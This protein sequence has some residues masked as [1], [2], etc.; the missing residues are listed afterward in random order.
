[1]G[2]IKVNEIEK[3][4]ASEITIN[5]TVKVDT[6]AEKTSGSGVTV[7]G[8]TIK[9]T[10]F[11]EPVKIKGYTTTQMNALSGMGAGDM[12]YNSTV[13]T[14]YV[15]NGVTW[16]AMS[17]NTYTV[18]VDYLIIAGG[19]AG[20]GSGTGGNGGG[21]GAGGYLN[22]YGSD[23]SG[24]GGSN[25][26]SQSLNVD[27]NYTVTIGAGGVGAA[28]NGAGTNGSNSIF[29]TATATGGGR[30]GDYNTDAAI[31]GSGGGGTSGGGGGSR[32]GAA[33]TANQ[34]FAGGDAAANANAYPGA[35]GGGAGGV[36]ANGTAGNNNAG[37]NGGAGLADTITGSA[38][39]R[40]GGGGG[41][42]DGVASAGGDAT[43]GGGDG[44]G[45]STNGTAGT[46]NTGGGGGAA[47][48]SADGG[49][50]GSGVVVLRYP[51]A[52][53]ITVGSGLTS[54]DANTAVGSDKYTTITAGSGNISFAIA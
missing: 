7:D 21:G 28:W 51:A 2:K 15:Y 40:G 42:S 17:G 35:G 49:N 39:S 8:L 22:S 50:G 25:L 29:N 13:G 16:S 46:V 12:I 31:G 54:S 53:N 33:G 3:H 43:H 11:D 48:Q 5:D 32:F 14:L 52:Y 45:T 6:I 23:N 41:G 10:G 20:G 37:G 38:V 44:G 26:D 34:G 24:G 18:A 27:T 1:M 9:D 30:G 4:D 36:G 19:G 47:G